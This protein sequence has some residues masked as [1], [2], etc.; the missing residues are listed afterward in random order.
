MAVIAIM[1]LFAVV[2]AHKIELFEK[3]EIFRKGQPLQTIEE[4]CF[5]ITDK[6]I[7]NA[8]D[9]CYFCECD[10]STHRL[11]CIDSSDSTYECSSGCF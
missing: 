8:S 4:F 6:S 9:L 2:N 5:A 7:C 1:V 11:G 10:L 3:T